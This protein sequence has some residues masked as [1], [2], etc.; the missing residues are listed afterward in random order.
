MLKKKIILAISFMAVT[1]AGIT[2]AQSVPNQITV[3]GGLTPIP[4]MIKAGEQLVG[5]A[6][7]YK[8]PHILYNDTTVGFQLFCAGAGLDTPSINTG[9]RQ[10]RP[11][12]LELC[13]KNGVNEIVQFKLG[14]DALVT[15]QASRGR[16]AGLSRKELFLAIAKDV[17]D[18]KDNAKLIPNPYKSWKDINSALPD[19][20]IQ[21]LGPEQGIGLY[22]TF[23]KGIVLP[24]C[25]QLGFFKALEASDP[26][27]FETVCKN[28]RKDGAFAEYTRTPDAIQGLKSKPE[29]LG[30]VSLTTVVKEGLENI[31]L[32]NMDPTFVTVS[33]DMYELTFPMLVFVKKSHVDLI[34]GFKEYLDELT[35]EAAIGTTGYYYNMGVI[36]LPLVERKQ[37]RADVKALKVMS[38]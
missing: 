22:Q 18:P 1:I 33:R 23:I 37:V 14:H 38:E 28:I 11:A 26:K 34:P 32:D 12:E 16:F 24:G 20:K 25:R 9:T 15:A 29:S 31:P 3:A 8:P 10:M 2:V 6:P 4:L 21:V 13:R 5:R 7:Q 30:I 36:P 35:S 27:E 17:P 19:L